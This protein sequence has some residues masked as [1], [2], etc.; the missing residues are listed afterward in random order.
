MNK[1]VLN[2]KRRMGAILIKVIA[3]VVG[4]ILL[5]AKISAFFNVLHTEFSNMHCKGN[6]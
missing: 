1:Y 4:N 2:H 3:K 5:R 6:T